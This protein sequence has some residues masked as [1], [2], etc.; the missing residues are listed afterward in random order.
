MLLL[1]PPLGTSICKALP[2][3]W[4]SDHPRPYPS[5]GSQYSTRTV[6]KG[7]F[8]LNILNVWTTNSCPPIARLF[9]WMG[10]PF[11]YRAP[12]EKPC[13]KPLPEKYAIEKV[14]HL[15]RTMIPVPYCD[16]LPPPHHKQPILSLCWR[17]F[18]KILAGLK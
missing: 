2:N 16:T 1:G 9:H 17:N 4:L 8:S 13:R 3:P 12:G 5:T 15:Q 14:K 7:S 18:R 10:E 6:R 11:P